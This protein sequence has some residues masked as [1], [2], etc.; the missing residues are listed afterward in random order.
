MRIDV[1][2]SCYLLCLYGVRRHK[3]SSEFCFPKILNVPR[4]DHW[5]LSGD[6][7]RPCSQ[8]H[9]PGLGAGKG[10]GNDVAQ[11]S[12]SPV[13]QAIKC[14]PNNLKKNRMPENY[15]LDS[16]WDIN[17]PR[18]QRARLRITCESNVSAV[19]SLWELV[20]FV[21]PSELVSEFDSSQGPWYFL[22][23][24]LGSWWLIHLTQKM[25]LFLF[26]YSGSPF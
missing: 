21:R 2:R 23:P 17:L 8:G 9:F 16:D 7:T 5:I 13:G 19:V 15:F 6:K 1:P 3:G 20:S 14:L 18:F 12:L 22:C 24:T 26:P 11:N 25:H 10:P 4:G